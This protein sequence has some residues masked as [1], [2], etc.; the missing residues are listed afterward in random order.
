[1]HRAVRL[2]AGPEREHII[3]KTR[4]VSG[5]IVPFNPVGTP[6]VRSVSAEVWL[7]LGRG[8]GMVSQIQSRDQRVPGMASPQALQQGGLDFMPVAGLSQVLWQ[9]LR[10]VACSQATAKG[11]EKCPRQPSLPE[12]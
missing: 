8:E 10:M 7:G 1:M 5:P 3:N 6:V 4:L 9:G 12:A 2:Y 11:S